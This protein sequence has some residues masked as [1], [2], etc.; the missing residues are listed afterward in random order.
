M[1]TGLHTVADIYCNQCSQVVGWKYVSAAPNLLLSLVLITVLLDAGASVREKPEVQGGE[2]YSREVRMLRR[3]L[4]HFP[5]FQDDH[6][7]IK[8]SDLSVHE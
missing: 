5:A 4:Q 7:F 3:L 2:I 8:F 6:L 1:T